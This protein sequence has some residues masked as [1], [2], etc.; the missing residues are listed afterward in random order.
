MMEKQENLAPKNSDSGNGSQ[1]RSRYVELA[2]T[3]CFTFLTGA[4]HPEELVARAAE[5]GYDALAVTDH[6]TL[7]GLVRAHTAAREHGIRLIVGCRLTLDIGADA[8]PLDALVYP[9]DLDAYG[10]LG[11]M[12][13]T[14]K[15]RAGKGGCR[16]AP[17]DLMRE[18]ASLIALLPVPDGPGDAFLAAARDLRAV[19]GD[20]L[21]LAAK[22]A[23]RADD[24]ERLDRAART[25]DALGAP[26]AAI[27][28]V[29]LH[30][31][32]RQPLRDVLACIRLGCSLEEAGRR[33][34]PHAEDHLKSPAEMA[35]LF[36][37]FPDAIERAAE[38]AER[39]AG[40]DLADLRYAYPREAVPAGRSAER[41]LGDLAW[42]GAERRYPGGVPAKVRRQIAHELALIAELGYAHY[43]LTV[44]DLVT[45]AR[46][47]GILCQGRGAAA[48]SAV[49]YC[50]GITAVDPER[51]DVLFERFVS[52]E[53]REPPDIDVDFEHERREEVIQYVYEKYGR[54][55]AAITAEVIAYRPKS[56]VRD[57]GKAL[58]FS[59]ACVDRLAKEVERGDDAWDA[60]DRLRA[61]GLDPDAPAVKRW[62]RLAR[63]LV[64]VP[65][66]RS[67]HVGGFVI[68]ERPI[69]ELVPVEPAAMAGRTVIEWDKHDIEAMGMMKIDVLALGMLTALRKGLE[70]IGDES[71]S[72]GLADVPAEDPAVYE[73]VSAADTVGVFQIESR[74]QRAMLPRLKPRCF[75]DLVIEVAIVRPGPIQGE[76]V[77]PYLRRRDGEEAPFYPDETARTVLERTLGV[78]LFQEQ[79]MALAIRCAGFSAEEAE[80]LR[81]AMSAWKA[82]GHEI[83][84]FREKL[85]AG[86]AA[87]GYPRSFGERCFEQIKG[88]GEYGF[89]ESH[90][91]SFALLVYVSAWLKRHHPAA[92]ACALLN[93]QPLGF[94]AP[95]EIVRDAREHGVAVRPVDVHASEW[96]CT[97]ERDE[98]GGPALRLGMRR[99][100]GL[101]R[102]DADAI[103][104]AVRERGPF[105]SLGALKR[106]SGVGAGALK[107][108]AEADAFRSFGLERQRALWRIRGMPERSM[109]LWEGGPE[110]AEDGAALPAV[111][112]LEGVLRDYGATGLSLRAH[113]ISFLRRRLA[114]R[115]AEPA[116]ALADAARA[117]HGR[118]VRVAGLCRLRQRPST[119]KGVVFMSL[120]DETG[121]AQLLVH[122]G[123]YRRFRAATAAAALI[124]EGRVERRGDVVHVVAKRLE[125]LGAELDGLLV[126]ARD[127]R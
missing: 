39:A 66:H 79:A 90:A 69:A 22:A 63:E 54:D 104:A 125:D 86:M 91:A 97:L 47:R 46:R 58:G 55:R 40:L 120:E 51:V 44:H 52:R 88:F 56:A 80:R 94:Y 17:A 4:S 96:D 13:T 108:L 122:P 74:A 112:P 111:P 37:R 61:A 82:K 6:H 31:P 14:G 34:P 21:Y 28:D 25:A 106:A 81:R 12:L 118:T 33:L 123:V 89:P 3:T 68:T 114:E 38:I 60:A 126:G 53:R 20:R 113:P 85:V 76:M 32:D 57:V 110:P 42:A 2:T 107:R 11:R 27:N 77:H 1:S 84:R 9:C 72:P 59:L 99:V 101:A 26:L 83:H 116:E 43:F 117:P 115:G 75:Y 87:R 95:D 5:L 70:L 92:F 19:L 7:G 78:P 62:A 65:R 49:C 10:R 41:H 29:T 36:A 105:A 30:H 93:S 71:G 35:R 109:P 8:A 16:L 98:P 119:A 121:S 23:Y 45:F 48:N 100:Q 127:F 73:M 18:P 64:G 24:A 124:A 15:S 67:Q 102:A 50:L 103:A